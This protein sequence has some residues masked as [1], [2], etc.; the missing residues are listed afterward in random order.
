[1]TFWEHVVDSVLSQ[2][3]EDWEWIV[4]DDTEQTEAFW[5]VQDAR[6]V[7]LANRNG[8]RVSDGVGLARVVDNLNMAA[9]QSKGDYLLFLD[10]D[11]FFYPFCLW[12]I[13]NVLDSC[14][15]LASWG[16]F[17]Q[18]LLISDGDKTWFGGQYPGWPNHYDKEALER[19]NFIDLGALFVLRDIYLQMGGLS[20]DVGLPD[21]A[22]IQLLAESAPPVEIDQPL[23]IYRFWTGGNIS[24]AKYESIVGSVGIGNYPVYKPI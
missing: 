6:V 24:R 17:K 2:Y 8:V 16:Y 11:N 15:K 21:Y 1:M 7:A 4:V 5:N 10:D 9:E 23:G 18:H 14:N 3:F 12:T 20:R 22:L 13:A 19:A